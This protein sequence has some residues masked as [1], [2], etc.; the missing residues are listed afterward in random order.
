VKKLGQTP[1]RP[2]LSLGS[3][4]FLL[5]A[6]PFFPQPPSHVLIVTSWDCQQEPDIG[7]SRR[8]KSRRVAAPG[9]PALGRCGLLLALA[10]FNFRIKA[11]RPRSVPL[12]SS[13]TTNCWMLGMFLTLLFTTTCAASPPR[14]SARLSDGTRL[15]GNDLSDWHKPELSPRLD[16]QPLM[17]PNRPALWM[18]NRRLTPASPPPAFVEMITGDCLPGVAISYRPSGRTM[19]YKPGITGS[20]GQPFLCIHRVRPN[21]RASE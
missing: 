17:E 12:H 2:T 16:G 15:D 6:S 5:G 9:V 3:S 8:R 4:R 13:D 14:F 21:R 20:S 18:L 10:V 7:R 1:S 19:S 11:V